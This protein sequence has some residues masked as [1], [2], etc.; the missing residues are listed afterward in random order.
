VYNVPDGMALITLI[1]VVLPDDYTPPSPIHVNQSYVTLVQVSS[2]TLPPVGNLP[3]WLKSYAVADELFEEE[4]EY[5]N[6]E[7]YPDGK[8]KSADWE[9]QDP[10]YIIGKYDNPNPTNNPLFNGWHGTG[11]PDKRL[12]EIT[13]GDVPIVEVAIDDN[14]EHNIQAAVITVP[15]ERDRFHF[16]TQDVMQP[17]GTTIRKLIFIPRENQEGYHIEM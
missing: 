4:S 8:L 6:M 9:G 14:P 1:S 16:E 5:T 12:D 11:Y 2:D 13:V 17:D 10:A 15:I 7:Y 3:D